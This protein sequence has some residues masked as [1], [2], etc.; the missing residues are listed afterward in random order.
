MKSQTIRKYPGYFIFLIMS[1]SYESR[2]S[3]SSI[4]CFSAPR[5]ASSCSRGSRMLEALPDDVLEIVVEREPGGHVE[6]RQVVLRERQIDV[7]AVGDPDGVA[8]A[9]RDESGKTAA[10]SS[11]VFR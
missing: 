7:A 8:P 1:I 5:P 2:R 10:I 11:A 3:Y 4:V 9:R 6:V